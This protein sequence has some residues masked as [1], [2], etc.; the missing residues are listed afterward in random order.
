MKDLHQ[1]SRFQDRV[2]KAVVIDTGTIGPAILTGLLYYYLVKPRVQPFEWYIEIPIAIAFCVLTFFCLV[3]VWVFVGGIAVED[4]LN[5][6]AKRRWG[7]EPLGMFMDKLSEKERK[8][9]LEKIDRLRR[10][11]PA[12]TC[13]SCIFGVEIYEDPMFDENAAMYNLLCHRFPPHSVWP[14]SRSKKNKVVVGSSGKRGV[15]VHGWAMV[16]KHDW[17]G[18]YKPRDPEVNKYGERTG[19]TGE[20]FRELR[21]KNQDDLE[22]AKE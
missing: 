4:A 9:Q 10:L 15:L 2:I 19:M 11:A 8:E 7:R 16:Y 21:R 13:D 14:V 1:F 20:E 12:G 5:G 6:I 3:F 22:R 18:E 17:C